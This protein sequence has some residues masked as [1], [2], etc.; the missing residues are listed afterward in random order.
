MTSITSMTSPT[1]A[2]EIHDAGLL[3]VDEGGEQPPGGA[4][5]PGYALLDGRTVITGR[6]AVERAR[7]RP[8][9]VNHRFWQDL[10]S[11]PLARPFPAELT[12]ADLAHAHLGG[13]WRSLASRAASVIL[14]VPGTF[15]EAQLGLLLGVARA[16]D[17]PVAGMV[18][19]AVAAASGFAAPRILH[20]DAHLHRLVATELRSADGELLRRRVEV[21]DDAGLIAVTDALARRVARLFVHAT[22][23]DPLH[24][25]AS[26]QE[27][28]RRLAGWLEELRAGDA[29]EIALETPRGEQRIEATVGD[30]AA[31][32]APFLDRALDLVGALRRGGEPAALLV[33]HRLAALPGLERRLGALDGCDWT[34]LGEGAAAAGALR[35]R[36]AIVAAEDEDLTFVIRLPAAADAVAVAPRERPRESRRL[37]THLVRDGLAYPIAGTPFL[38]TAPWDGGGERAP[39]CKI[40][41]DDGVVVA[42]ASAAGVSL[43]GEPFSGRRTLA[44]GDRLRVGASDRPVELELVAVEE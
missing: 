6:Q 33:S 26:E 38:A 39:A 34:L 12:A 32:A 35:A 42:E 22:R 31:A 16:C 41:V 24:S 20:L 27:L 44:A 11:A 43:N 18:D 4:A 5:S 17:V 28:Y 10:G 15:T 37:P 30:L 13:F 19:A 9:F 3:A 2:L 1:L 7:L 40:F 8:R 36:Q 14:A 29:V 25:A 23:F 21:A